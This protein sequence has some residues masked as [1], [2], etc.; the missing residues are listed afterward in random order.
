MTPLLMTKFDV[1]KITMFKYTG[2]FLLLSFKTT[3]NEWESDICI[4]GF[5]VETLRLV[6]LRQFLLELSPSKI[7]LDIHITPDLLEGYDYARDIIG[8]PKPPIVEKMTIQ[9]HPPS[10]SLEDLFW[11]CHPKFLVLYLESTYLFIRY[12][13]AKLLY[14]TLIEQ[15]NNNRDIFALR[16]LQEVNIGFFRADDLAGCH[17]LPCRTLLDTEAYT[18]TSSLDAE[19]SL[20]YRIRAVFQLRWDEFIARGSWTWMGFVPST[21]HS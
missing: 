5:S 2:R 18:V 1:P 10:L 14:D 21:G 8:S 20:K 19:A 3:S 11:T 15:G 17:P 6:E 7:Y 16:D 13:F 12:D 4:L 9:T